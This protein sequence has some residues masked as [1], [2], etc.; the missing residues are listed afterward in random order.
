MLNNRPT[1]S[2]LHSRVLP[3]S[4]LH[5]H[6][7]VLREAAEMAGERMRACEGLWGGGQGGAGPS[8]GCWLSVKEAHEG[9]R[10]L[11]RW[12]CLSFQQDNFISIPPPQL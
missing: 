2:V 12:L 9:R 4:V 3:G 10:P 7:T 6:F 5:I 1:G 8:P 11:S